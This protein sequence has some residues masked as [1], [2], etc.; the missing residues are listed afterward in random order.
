MPVLQALP[1]VEVLGPVKVVSKGIEVESK[2]LLKY[3]YSAGAQLAKSLQI[4]TIKLSAGNKRNNLTTGRSMRPIR[5]RMDDFDV[6]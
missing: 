2:I 3:E 4:E 6:L 1:G 5:I